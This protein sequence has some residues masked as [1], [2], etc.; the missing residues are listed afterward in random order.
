[1]SADDLIATLLDPARSDV[2]AD[3]FGLYEELRAHG[4]VVFSATTDSWVTTS[5][6][7]ATS[8]LRDA[9]WST[10]HRKATNRG[11][12]SRRERSDGEA[13]VR[14]RIMLFMDPPEHTRMRGLVSKA[15]T[16]RIVDRLRSH[17]QDLT[18]RFLDEALAADPDGHVELM[19]AFASRLPVTVICELLGVPDDQRDLFQEHTHHLATTLELHVTEAQLQQAATSAIALGAVL[20]PLFEERR[21]QPTDDLLSGLVHAEVDGDR[22]DTADVF[23][24]IVLLLGAGHETTTNLIG[25]GLLALLR[26]DAARR[27]WRE[28]PDLDR[29]AVDELLRY[30]SPVQLTG[31]TAN[32]DLDLAGHPVRRGDQVLLLLGAANRDPRRF[33]HPDTL[34][35]A[36]PDNAHVAFGMGA[37][38]CLG[39]ALARLE[40]Q[41][42]L[43]TLVRRFPDVSCAVEDPPWRDTLTLRGLQALPLRLGRPVD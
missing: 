2:R 6:A 18:D 19:S 42:A 10:D 34:D 13:Q 5:H 21:A 20:F 8:V 1:V 26:D 37:H 32:E 28:S 9:R 36:R 7:V 16:P 3:P 41:V 33:D 15:F 40:G 12:G 23:T 30:D 27:R 14:S 25:N 38:Y 24:T 22:L 4:D 11:F 35:L 29:T 17:V 39:A 31:R 43:G